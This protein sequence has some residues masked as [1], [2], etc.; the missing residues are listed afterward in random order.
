LEST[1]HVDRHIKPKQ[2]ALY[3]VPELWLI[4]PAATTMDILRLRDGAYELASHLVSG[5][6]ITSPFFPGFS[7]LLDSLWES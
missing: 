4:D 3:G 6:D 5:Q 1:A 7:L 2:Y